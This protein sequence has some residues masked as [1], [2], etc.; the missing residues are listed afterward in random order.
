MKRCD[1]LHYRLSDIKL[2]YKKNRIFFIVA[3]V[4]LLVG[5]AAAIR[6]CCV[7]TEKKEVL[8]LAEYIAKG[9]Y[10]F[11]K[12]FLYAILLPTVLCGSVLLLSINYYSI[13]AFYLELII[14][15]Y[16]VF[17]NSLL[18]ITCSFLPGIITFLLYIVPI[19][20]SDAFLITFLWIEVYCAVGY[21][22]KNKI[23]YVLP[24]RC[25]I[26][27]TK[28]ILC[29]HTITVICV[30]VVYTAIISLLFALIF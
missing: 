29:R 26:Q 11:G 16:I 4:C 5:F 3:A 17:K 12:V 22:C 30:N 21:P 23:F 13:F 18:A 10:P 9:E 1:K 14:A 2:L 8:S 15:S 28:K 7:Q 27:T 6:F 24:Y 20:L 19:V 25:H